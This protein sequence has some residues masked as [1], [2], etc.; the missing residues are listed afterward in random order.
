MFLICNTYI[1]ALDP[2]SDRCER[3]LAGDIV[4]QHD[5]VRPPEVRLSDGPEPLLARGV[6][7]LYR[8]VA[9]VHPD[10]LH[11]EVHA[12]GGAQ[13]GHEDPLRDPVDEGGLANRCI[14]CKHH[15]VRSVW[16]S[17]G[18]QVSQF[19]HSFLSFSRNVWNIRKEGL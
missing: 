5:A 8:D 16:G 17:S 19:A 7:Q 14:A 12:E 13:V 2:M 9:I 11:L 15:F 1:N 6:P 10:G 3:P 4:E 18:L